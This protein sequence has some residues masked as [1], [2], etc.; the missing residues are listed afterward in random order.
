M[1]CW[2]PISEYPF[3]ERN[4]PVVLARTA[5]KTP[6]LVRYLGLHQRS[7]TDKRPAAFYVCPAVPI[8]YG[9]QQLDFVTANHVVEFMHIPA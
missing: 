9:E 5:D 1:T 3:T 6:Y 7:P 2:Q 8:F 4:S